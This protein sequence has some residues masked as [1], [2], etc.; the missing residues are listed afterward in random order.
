MAA[1]NA[2]G[3]GHDTGDSP[4]PFN[5]AALFAARVGTALRLIAA[6]SQRFTVWG[7]PILSLALYSDGKE[8]LAGG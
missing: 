2:W 3:N 4:V 8:I 5:I 6:D 1:V 7:P